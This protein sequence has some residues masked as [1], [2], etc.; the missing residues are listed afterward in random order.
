MLVLST[1]APNKPRHRRNPWGA[2]DARRAC[3][4]CG[5]GLGLAETYRPGLNLQ[6][7]RSVDK[8]FFNLLLS[9]V[10]LC[11]VFQPARQINS[12][13]HFDTII[14]LC[15]F[16]AATLLITRQER[17]KPLLRT[18]HLE[19]LSNEPRPGRK[20]WAAFDPRRACFAYGGSVR[21]AETCLPGVNLQT[22]ILARK[23]FSN[24]LLSSI[25]RLTVNGPSKSNDPQI[26][27]FGPTYSYFT[28]KITSSQVPTTK[29]FSCEGGPF[30]D[31]PR[32]SAFATHVR[33]INLRRRPL[34][35]CSWPIGVRGTGGRTIRPDVTLPVHNQL[36]LVQKRRGQARRRLVTGGGHSGAGT[37]PGARAREHGGRTASRARR[38]HRSRTR[39]R[40]PP[41][42]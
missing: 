36:A 17:P 3:F 2:L 37:R 18:P 14:A 22:V 20:S 34:W 5:D 33:K 38:R 1:C 12:Y 28:I 35:L 8:A 25:M 39:K 4:A 41:S 42:H 11:S 9:F 40:T 6:T 31:R 21:L 30:A 32:S 7:A 19:L 26:I 23:A 13:S 10:V 24:L 15:K 29:S 27:L 16:I